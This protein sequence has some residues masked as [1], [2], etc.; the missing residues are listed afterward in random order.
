L[1]RRLLPE[2]RRGY[3]PGADK[4]AGSARVTRIFGGRHL[5]RRSWG[6]KVSPAVEPANQPA[7]ERMITYA[8]V[9]DECVRV[10]REKSDAAGILIGGN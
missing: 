1:R 6:A 2:Y 8:C 4:I 5:R 10:R 7:S 3:I 9:H